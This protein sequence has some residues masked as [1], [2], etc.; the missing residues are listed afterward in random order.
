VPVFWQ[1][2]WNLMNGSIVYRLS[3]YMFM[4]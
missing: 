2:L 4:V 3:L 1:A